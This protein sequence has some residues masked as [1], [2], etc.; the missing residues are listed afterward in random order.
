MKL[1]FT[2]S[3]A[4]KAERRKPPI[5]READAV[6]KTIDMAEPYLLQSTAP[7]NYI[8]TDA[9][10]IQFVSRTKAF[11]NF[12]L[13]LSMKITKFKNLHALHTP[14]RTLFIADLYSRQRDYVQF[15][16]ESTQ[17][18]PQQACIL[19]ALTFLKPGT[20]IDSSA[21]KSIL[22]AIPH[23]EFYDI[24]E[25]SYQYVQKVDWS[26][27]SNKKQL[28]T[29]E[30]EYIIAALLNHDPSTAL[31]LQ[32]LSDIFAIKQKGGHFKTRAQKLQFLSKCH[33]QLSKLKYNSKEL[34]SI[35]KFINDHSEDLQLK[36]DKK[37]K[38]HFFYVKSH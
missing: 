16:R 15:E 1:T 37:V 14:G 21:L 20:I 34:Q 36:P 13:E 19:P 31:K 27:Y 22:H 5:A 12:L 11:S 6:D 26:L 28:M 25:K 33:E 10:S 29:S 35:Q 9:A 24:N 18:S 23:A 32:T 4:R 2:L 3:H 38:V 8:L 7:A 17:L 30:R